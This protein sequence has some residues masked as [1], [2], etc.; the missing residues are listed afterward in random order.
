MLVTYL[1][2]VIT[3]IM[4]RETTGNRNHGTYTSQLGR[5]RPL[6]T[7]NTGFRHKTVGISMGHLKGVGNLSL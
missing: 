2:M 3:Q 7:H 6:N 5:P 1:V 4:S